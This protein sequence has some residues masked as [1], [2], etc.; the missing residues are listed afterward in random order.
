MAIW[1][2]F[3]LITKVWH[4]QQIK[5]LQ[6]CNPIYIG[7]LFSQ[8]SEAI[9]KALEYMSDLQSHS[10]MGVVFTLPPRT[11]T[12]NHGMPSRCCN[13][14]HIWELFSLDGDMAFVTNDERIMLQSHSY[15]GACLLTQKQIER[16]NDSV[17]KEQCLF[18]G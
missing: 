10:Y 6:D 14:I 8:Q 16:K 7:E 17:V 4:K 1:E 11:L 2:S 5:S 9:N 3:P 15:M 18:S 13:P 12:V